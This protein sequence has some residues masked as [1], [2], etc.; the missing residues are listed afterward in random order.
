MHLAE[1][2]AR[3]DEAGRGNARRAMWERL[4]LQMDRTA[5]DNAHSRLKPLPQEAR[6]PF[7]AEAGPTGEIPAQARR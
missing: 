5:C 4:Q 2:D 1:V 7:G 3:P 6:P